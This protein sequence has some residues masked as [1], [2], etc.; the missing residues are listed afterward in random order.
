MPH[1]RNAESV[2]PSD[3]RHVNIVEEFDGYKLTVGV[4]DSFVGFQTCAAA[5]IAKA[6]ELTVL[7]VLEFGKRLEL[8][9]RDQEKKK[10]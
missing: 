9:L 3:W 4:T 6:S 2:T 10:K 1:S 5:K 7:E 8:W